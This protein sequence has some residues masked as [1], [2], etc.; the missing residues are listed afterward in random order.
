MKKGVNEI[1]R[2]K[3]G[4]LGPI[5]G[6]LNEVSMG[7]NIHSSDLHETNSTED[8][9]YRSLEKTIAFTSM[10]FCLIVEF[11]FMFSYTVYTQTFTTT[12]MQHIWVVD[13]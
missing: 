9:N 6:R 10:I 13:K 3:G 7:P 8:P 4:K 1:L 5:E 11:S 12:S 2:L